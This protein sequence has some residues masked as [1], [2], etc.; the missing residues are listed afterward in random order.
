MIKR[1]KTLDGLK[2]ILL[3]VDF[4]KDF[5]EHLDI[6]FELVNAEMI[7]GHDYRM[8]S[9]LMDVND[10]VDVEIE[11]YLAVYS[12]VYQDKHLRINFDSLANPWTVDCAFNEEEI[13]QFIWSLK[14][15]RK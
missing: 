4:R 5:H 14:D 7:Q 9:K 15:D 2:K 13:L 10:S 12:L 3:V 6:E 1:I 11:N 8:Y